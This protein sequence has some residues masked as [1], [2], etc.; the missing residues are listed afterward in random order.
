MPS[1]VYRL[2]ASF[3]GNSQTSTL[4]AQGSGVTSSV[5]GTGTGVGLRT[6]RAAVRY[7]YF[8]VYGRDPAG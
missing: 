7:R 6:N 8:V 4:R 2:R 5:T 3:I 1:T